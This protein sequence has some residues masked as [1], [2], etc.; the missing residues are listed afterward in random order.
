[1]KQ[2]LF[3]AAIILS[4]SACYG[5]AK[6]FASDNPLH[7]RLDSLIDHSV[8][9]YLQD[10]R[11]VGLSIGLLIK[12]KACFYNYGE[13]KA[14]NNKLPGNNTLYEIGSTTKTFTGILLGKA[15]L[16]KKIGLNDDIR[17]YLEGAYPNLEYKGVPIRVKDL[18]NHTSRITRIFPN[19]WERPEYDSLNPLH[20]YTRQLLYEGLHNMKMDT[21]PG[22]VSS[23]SNMAVALLGT[24]LED[25]YGQSYF[26]LVS[27]NILEPLSMKDTRI[28]ITALPADA[29][30]W[31]HN[32]KREPVPLWDLPYLPAMGA[33]RSTARDLISFI[34]ANNAGA[35]PAIVLSHQLTYGTSREGM[36]MNWFI[37]TTPGGYQ[38]LEH[39]GGTGGSRSSL[40]CFPRLHAGFVILSNSLANRNK[41][42]KALADIVVAEGTKPHPASA[43]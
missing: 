22:K 2:I 43:E 36:G 17:K 6:R 31:P 27:K 7:S 28:D 32:E 16:D 35:S 21:F 19:M 12:D 18:A 4:I 41:L 10:Q 24:L 26:S 13:T 39:S 15:V 11:A 3:N 1:M 37:H 23:Y 42:E 8:Q 34:S 20:D 29:I 5:Q 40:E 38:V 25:A 9:E 14:G 33:L 30:A